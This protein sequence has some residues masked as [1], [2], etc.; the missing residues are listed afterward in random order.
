MR[1]KI[2]V[3]CAGSDFSFPI[4]LEIGQSETAADLEQLVRAGYAEVIGGE[5]T[6][7]IET[8]TAELGAEK[9]VASKPRRRAKKKSAGVMEQAS[10]WLVTGPARQ[11]V[12]TALV[13]Q[14]LR[15]EHSEDDGLI[16]VMIVSATQQIED[17]T[18]RALTTRTYDM[19]LDRFPSGRASI[20]VPRPPL[21]SVSSITYTATDGTSTVLP[22]SEYRVVEKKE[23][24]EIEPAFGKSWPT[25]RRQGHSVAVRF[26]CG[27]GD[28]DNVP[29]PLVTAIMQTVSDLYENRESFITGTISA[30]LPFSARNLVWPYRMFG[31][32]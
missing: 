12:P 22:T 31:G 11:A 7:A 28:E 26:V 16:D 18:R 29:Q 3:S 27:Y 8:A 15:V 2:L 21:V 24:G 19:Y 4:G 13:K 9:A 6:R 20:M 25:A 32:F 10:L 5:P 17:M 1:V 14:Y 30:D 23:P